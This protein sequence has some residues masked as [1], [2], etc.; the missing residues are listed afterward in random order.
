MELPPLHESNHLEEEV[1]ALVKHLL[2]PLYHL[3]HL[4]RGCG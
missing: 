4:E 3:D 1:H 2:S